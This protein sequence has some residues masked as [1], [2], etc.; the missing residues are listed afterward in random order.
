MMRTLWHSLLVLGVAFS[1]FADAPGHLAQHMIDPT[2]EGGEEITT[3]EEPAASNSEET[4]YVP[5]GP[6]IPVKPLEEEDAKPVEPESPPSIP[7]EE[8]EGE[9]ASE[10]KEEHLD[11]EPEL[12]DDGD[13]GILLVCLGGGED[14][15]VMAQMATLLKRQG[16]KVTAILYGSGPR[17]E[18]FPKGMKIYEI[19]IDEEDP[20]YPNGV[21]VGVTPGE[22]AGVEWISGRVISSRVLACQHLSRS[23]WVDDVVRRSR[24]LVTPLFLHDL[25]ALTLAHRMSVPVVGVLTSRVGAWWAWEQLG[26]LPL[27]STTSVPPTTMEDSSIWS[28]TM[29]IARHYGYLSA[30]RHQWQVPTLTGLDPSWSPPPLQN[31]YS[32]LARILVAWDPLVHSY[33]PPTPLLVPVGGFSFETGHMTKDVLVPALLN[34]AGVI[35]VCPGGREAW[36]GPQALTELH[37]ALQPTSYTVLWRSTFPYLKPNVTMAVSTNANFVFKEELPLNDVLSH[38]RH[39]LMISTCGESELMASVSFATPILCLPVTTDQTLAARQLESLGVAEVIPAAEIT[40]AK[41]R[42]SVTKIVSDRGYR[43]RARKL[44][45]EFHDQ[46][47]SAADRLLFSLE[48]VLRKPYSRRYETRSSS[49]YLLQQSNADVYLFLLVLLTIL[50]AVLIAAGIV[51]IPI[52]MKKQKTKAE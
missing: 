7:Q 47:V 51:L 21:G 22:E 8:G 33:T 24:L 2:D 49:L 52:I 4:R 19:P 23:Q 18:P 38:P 34:R 35:S 36:L 28:R 40:A 32:S 11:L 44:G 31:L 5:E 17:E 39:R 6:P 14:E 3:E 43:E 20:L 37:A 12:S 25:C 41:V 48:R 42:E 13:N 30:I 46:P 10:E 16:H 29:N 15:V 9:P 26:I 27:L 45:E 1:L 50:M